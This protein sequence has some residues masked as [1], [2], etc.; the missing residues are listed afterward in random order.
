MCKSII[1]LRDR[2]EVDDED[3]H[4]V[5]AVSYFLIQPTNKKSTKILFIVVGTTATAST[6]FD[7]NNTP[8]AHAFVRHHPSGG[9]VTPT[10]FYA[11]KTALC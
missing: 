6:A 1:D 4:R 5:S 11:K 10:V 8:A 2:K 9:T 7:T 3:H